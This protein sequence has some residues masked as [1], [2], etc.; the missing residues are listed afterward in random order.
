MIGEQALALAAMRRARDDRA[1]S[2]S[3]G[4]LEREA[5]P[6]SVVQPIGG[7]ESLGIEAEASGVHTRSSRRGLSAS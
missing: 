4:D 3:G 1:G 6:A 5:A 7:R 2:T